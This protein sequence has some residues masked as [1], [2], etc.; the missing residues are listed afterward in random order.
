MP[1]NKRASYTEHPHVFGSFNNWLK[2]LRNNKDVDRKFLLRALFVCFTT[3]STIPLRLYESVRYGRTVKNTAIHPS[4]IFIIGHWRTGTTH[5]HNI[6]CRDK[7]L[8]YISMF[9]VTT[10]A[11]CLTG[12]KIIKRPMAFVQKRRHPTRE[13]DNIPL[14]VDNPEEEDVAIANMSPYSYLHMYTFPRKAP[15][16]FENYVT[17]FDNLPESTLAEWKECYLTIL[18]KATITT[19][20]KRLIMKNCANSARI[21]T[22]LDLFPDAKFI[23]ICRNPYDTFRSTFHLYK[24]TTNLCQLQEISFDEIEGWVLQFYAQIMRKF[25]ADKALIPEGN[26]VEVKYE[27]LEKSPLDQMRRVYETL[28]LPGFTEAEPAFRAY[29]ESITGYKKNVYKE[30]DD[31]IIRKVN[32]NWPFVFDE[33]G[34][35]RL[36][37]LNK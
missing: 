17:F 3:F 26:F 33:W 10:P 13:I 34:Y 23:H 25:L 32:Q 12:E 31:S 22:L 24:T 29:I 2:L 27:E 1:K 18:R 6:M 8:G 35:K 37:P 16:F 36:E 21:K 7:N 28:S 30:V 4:P 19:G 9:Q 11:F 5:L 14:S 15:F 20:G